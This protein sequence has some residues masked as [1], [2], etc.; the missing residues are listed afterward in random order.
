MLKRLIFAPKTKLLLCT[1]LFSMLGLL[2]EPS[3]ATPVGLLGDTVG[4]QLISPADSVNVSDN[5]VVANPGIEI[6]A[7]VAGTN[8][9]ASGDLLPGTGVAYDGEYA[10][11]KSFSIILRILE[12]QGN[13]TGWSSGAKYVFSSLD[14]FPADSLEI[15]GVSAA[16]TGGTISN[17]DT[18]WATFDS[19][20]QVSFAID[21]IQFN[22]AAAGTT[23]GQVTLTLLTRATGTTPPDTGNGVPE[24]GSLALVGLALTGVWLSRR[25]VLPR[26]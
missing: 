25:R 2:A 21:A 15:F 10:D 13:T 5:V 7:N 9:G 26:A 23:F 18:S 22:P 17:F 12:G 24:P 14:L 19:P 8:L 1:G 20:T 6:S 16:A 11:L 3:H 4:V